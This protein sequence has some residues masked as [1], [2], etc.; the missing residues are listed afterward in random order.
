MYFHLS[1][2]CVCRCH[3]Y[4]GKM[5]DDEEYEE[6]VEVRFLKL[7]TLTSVFMWRIVKA[8]WVKII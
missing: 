3:Y 7:L 8:V 2:I 5:A 6:V 4:S 1:G